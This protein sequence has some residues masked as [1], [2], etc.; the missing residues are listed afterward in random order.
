ML[1]R[2]NLLTSQNL[3]IKINKLYESKINALLI[4]FLTIFTFIK[5]DKF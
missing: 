3:I 5:Y 1:L 4:T 2:S